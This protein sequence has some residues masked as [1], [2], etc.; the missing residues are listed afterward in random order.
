[1]R[2]VH[3]SL[4]NHIF[5]PCLRRLNCTI[6]PQLAWPRRREDENALRRDLV[7][8]VQIA[9]PSLRGIDGILSFKFMGWKPS[10]GS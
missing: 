5:F 4:H 1:L 2:H 6:T 3:P 9:L 8:A 7:S 10:A